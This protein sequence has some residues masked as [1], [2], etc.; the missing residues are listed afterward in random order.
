MKPKKSSDLLAEMDDLLRGSLAL[1]AEA[2]HQR[3]IDAV[4]FA[5]P[6]YTCQDWSCPCQTMILVDRWKRKGKRRQMMDGR[7]VGGEFLKVGETAFSWTMLETFALREILPFRAMQGSMGEDRGYRCSVRNAEKFPDLYGAWVW[8]PENARVPCEKR[9]RKAIRGAHVDIVIID[10]IAAWDAELTL[11]S[12]ADC[13][14]PRSD[15][16]HV[17]EETATFEH[18]FRVR[19]EEE[20]E[21]CE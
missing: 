16:R 4:E 2:N 10:E 15:I 3:A 9:W 7:W 19:V 14:E 17:L 18:L 20:E 5:A 12:C 1:Q 13:G 21:A 11:A 6:D 8:S